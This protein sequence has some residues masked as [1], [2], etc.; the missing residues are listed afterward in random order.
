PWANVLSRLL[1]ARASLLLDDRVAAR[2]LVDEAR[3]HLRLV[4]DSEWAAAQLDELSGMVRAARE[5]LPLGPSSLTTAELRVLQFLP[6]NPRFS[7][8]A[9]RLFVSPNTA[10]THAAAIYRKL[11]TRSRGQAVE[12]AR[13]AGLLTDAGWQAPAS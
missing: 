3:V 12:L 8:I 2:T 9:E 13:Q 11:G 6:T 4:P 1:L 7:E 10:K 5:V